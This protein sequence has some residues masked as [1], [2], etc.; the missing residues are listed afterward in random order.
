MMKAAMALSR[1]PEKDDHGH[2][3]PGVGVG[4]EASAA[5]PAPSPFV[6]GQSLSTRHIQIKQSVTGRFVHA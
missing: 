6:P 4:G 5:D 3:F 2:S 1:S